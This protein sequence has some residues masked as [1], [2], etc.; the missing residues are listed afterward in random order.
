M[1]TSPQMKTSAQMETSACDKEL[2][3]KARGKL[4]LTGEYLVLHGA[5]ALALPLN[6]GQS[7]KVAYPAQSKAFLQ[8]T[9]LL[10]EGRSEERRVGKEGRSWGLSR[11]Y[12]RSR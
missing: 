5:R 11:H 10:P 2:H 7:M 1:K 4:L 6:K 12:E 9:A 8:W 3:F